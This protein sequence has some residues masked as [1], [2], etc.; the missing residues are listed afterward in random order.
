MML[1][2]DIFGKRLNQL[3]MKLSEQTRKKML[4]LNKQNAI[5]MG[6]NP[7]LKKILLSFPF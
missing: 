7:G 5:R 3:K 2:K 6:A 1:Q 4:N